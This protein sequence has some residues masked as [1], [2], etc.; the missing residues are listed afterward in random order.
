MTHYYKIQQTV[1]WNVVDTHRDAQYP[2]NADASFPLCLILFDLTS[3]FG[4]CAQKSEPKSTK[5][6]PKHLTFQSY[7]L[8]T[9][10]PKHTGLS[11]VFLFIYSRG[12]LQVYAPKLQSLP[13]SKTQRLEEIRW[14]FRGLKL[15]MT[16]KC[17]VRSWFLIVHCLYVPCVTLFGATVLLPYF[18][19]LVSTS[20][21]TLLKNNCQATQ[22]E[23][24]QCYLQNKT[25]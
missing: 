12:K 7:L 1:C 9:R 11:I 19:T 2:D 17:R 18:S 25:N 6:H 4:T 23:N 13:M 21:L 5:F 24:W 8:T 3:S 14:L 20:T 10:G 15:V 16:L 22:N